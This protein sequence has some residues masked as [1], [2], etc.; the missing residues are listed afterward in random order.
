MEKDLITKEVTD[1]E[2]FQLVQSMKTLNVEYL[3]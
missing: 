3:K 2:S 1:V